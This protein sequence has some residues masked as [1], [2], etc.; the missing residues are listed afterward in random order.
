MAGRNIKGITIEIGGDTTKLTKAL[1][2]V[3][4]SIR[5]T[6]QKLKDVNR[7]LKFNPGNTELLRQ[8]QK[9][10]ADSI[11][12]TK[13][14]LKQLKEAQKQAE[15]QL[16]EGKIGQEE[17]DAL[18]REIIETESKLKN[19]QKQYKEFGSVAKQ[20]LKE[21]GDS[22]KEFG[23]KVTDVGENITKNVTG[24]ILA[25]GGASL[26]AFKSVDSGYDEM[27]K[28][29][30]ATGDA[31]K[32]LQGILENVATNVPTDFDTA[33]KAIGEVATRFDVAGQDLEYLSEK[34]IKFAELNNT[35][36]VQ[37][38][39]SVQKAM[40]AYGLGVED[41]DSYLDRL[42]KTAQETG[43]DVTKLADNVATNAAQ[44][45]ELGLGIEE[46]TVFMGKLDK[47]G[48]DSSQV[49]TGLRKALKKATDSGKPLNEALSDLQDTL[50][51]TEDDTEA[52]S[53]AYDLFGTKSAPA[54]ADA[55]KDGR[56]NFEDL[57][58]AISD[59]GGSI[60]DTFAEIDDPIRDLKTKFNELKVVGAK[61][62][63]PLLS[64]LAPAI[65]KLGQFISDLKDKWD[66]LSPAQ[67]EAI[68]KALLV[69]AA[70]GPILVIVGN[71]IT[72]IGGLVSAI[73]LL[74]SPIGIV[75]AVIGALIA[76]GILLYKNWDTIKEKA[77]EIW[78]KIKDFILKAIQY[79]KKS[80][81][82]HIKRVYTF[83]VNIWNKVKNF[84]RNI[85]QGLKSDATSFASGLKDAIM[86][87]VNR[88]HD[89]W[90]NIWNKVKDFFGNIW[91]VM[92]DKASQGVQGI[93]DTISNKLSSL[94]NTWTN[95][96]NEVKNA[97]SNVWESIK[98]AIS[99][100]ISS[101]ES[102]ISGFVSR[103]RDKING[104]M[105]AIGNANAAAA[106][107]NAPSAPTKKNTHTISTSALTPDNEL[108]A[109]NPAT[110]S[111]LALLEAYL[112]YLAEQQDIYIDGD[113]LV[114]ATAPAINKTLGMI[115]IRE[116]RR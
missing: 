112:P 40:A 69:A 8:K 10:L 2:N 46:S 29:T 4:K 23:G 75:I 60:E 110:N 44:F 11:T 72:V 83:W 58:G 41:A 88:I 99:G 1:S 55:V 12:Q 113:K 102:A 19:L 42:N 51:N 20:K 36:V 15:Q 32:E 76:I 33:G 65:E 45:K 28:K 21:V 115:Q 56:I 92:K 86:A 6:Q 101:I 74:F 73:G 59:A 82:D 25:L 52:L 80:I 61:V 108:I 62:A 96:W 84:F 114:G 95:K 50:L 106:G 81:E 3:D 79:I 18:Q 54:I 85:W 14:R 66:S 107:V 43:V 78:T 48:L 37:S 24:P 87:Q 57:A 91:G 38:V 64:M 63:E 116:R 68:E 105:T 67:Q 47:S 77:V 104:I 97:V 53:E 71:I 5:T 35:D 109:T 90:V 34:F 94:K 7:L 13:D 17:Y 22:M 98:S 27:I 9:A 31:A 49:M 30:G 111:I 70:V 93:A 103:V 100:K 16:K 26:A 39:D 89:F